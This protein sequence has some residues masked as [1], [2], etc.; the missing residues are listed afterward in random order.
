MG[1]L[2]KSLRWIK[3]LLKWTGITMA[4][5]LLLIV[6]SGLCY[7]LMMPTPQEPL[8]KLIA[9]DGY[10][11]HIVQEGEKSNKPTLVIEAGAGLST[12]F[13]HWLSE[14]FKI[15]YACHSL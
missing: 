4:T 10:Q 13:Y 9:M 14:G 12:E 15:A 5:L 7:R 3:R 11:L 1:I 8:G 6:L 2:N